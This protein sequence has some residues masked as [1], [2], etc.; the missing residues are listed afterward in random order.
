MNLKKM[1]DFAPPQDKASRPL[2]EL[3]APIK[4]ISHY[5]DAVEA[6]DLFREGG[7]VVEA[8]AEPEASAASQIAADLTLVGIAWSSNP[9]A[10][11]EDKSTQKTYFLKKGQ[12]FGS[13]V[14]VEGIFK[15]KVVLSYQGEEFELK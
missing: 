7:P 14:K 3:A 11:V 1:P 13:R 5:L 10:I 6:R 8:D 12:I 4:P 9:D 15:N 2:R